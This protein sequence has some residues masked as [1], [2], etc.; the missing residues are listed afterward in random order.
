MNGLSAFFKPASIAVA[1][2][3]REPEKIG[4]VIYKQ[5]KQNKEKGI[6]AADI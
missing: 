4:H 6:L 5:L 1:G 2:A 3:S